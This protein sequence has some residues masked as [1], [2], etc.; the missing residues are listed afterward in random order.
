[1]S[2]V[3]KNQWT[4]TLNQREST[5][6]ATA[7]F[8]FSIAGQLL[9]IISSFV[10]IA[11]LLLITGSIGSGWGARIG[12]VALALGATGGFLAGSWATNQYSV[13]RRS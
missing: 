11:G 8:F 5:L 6:S 9:L 10:A 7:M 12:G 1:M 13:Q 2:S 4:R 3:P